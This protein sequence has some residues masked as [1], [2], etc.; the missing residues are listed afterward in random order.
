MAQI[1]GSYG[2]VRKDTLKMV[3]KE[4]LTYCVYCYEGFELGHHAQFHISE[5]RDKKRVYKPMPAKE[6]AAIVSA[7]ESAIAE[8]LPGVLIG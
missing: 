8:Y 1:S 3:T 4:G 7:V 6:K 2:Y 5:C